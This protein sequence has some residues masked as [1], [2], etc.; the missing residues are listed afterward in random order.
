MGAKLAGTMS[1]I[2]GGCVVVEESF[3]LQGVS[4]SMPH[5]DFQIHSKLG[6]TPRGIRLR[7]WCRINDGVS[8][9]VTNRTTTS[10]DP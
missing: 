10:W 3:L 8:D 9:A 2:G 4:K 1:D 7:H 6:C 5:E